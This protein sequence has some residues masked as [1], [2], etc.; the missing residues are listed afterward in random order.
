MYIKANFELFCDQFKLMG[1]EQRF[2]RNAL[3]LI[4]DELEALEDA[5]DD[6]IVLDVISI[7][8]DYTEYDDLDAYKS[9]HGIEWR[10]IEVDDIEGYI[11]TTKNG[12]IVC[13]NY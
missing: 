8:C 12:T 1:R 5:S 9:D 7:C 6:Y 3:A 13:N 11:G 4:F 2:S 10:D